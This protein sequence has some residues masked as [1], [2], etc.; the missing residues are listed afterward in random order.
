MEALIVGLIL[1]M[2]T[3]GVDQAIKLK[4]NK[5]STNLQNVAKQIYTK[6]SKNNSLLEK[7]ADAYNRNDNEL[8]SELLS[9][10]G[11]GTRATKLKKA[12]EEAQSS[13]N[14]EKQS[15][16]DQNTQLQ[17]AYNQA[18]QASYNTSDLAGIN[19][20]KEVLNNLGVKTTSG[21]VDS[22]NQLV[23]GGLKLNEVH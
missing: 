14:K 5:V 7:L 16:S 13:Y 11:F 20:G 4:G 21:S 23:E 18:S 9:G 8:M 6:I 1:A 22:V 19:Q 2:A 10:A 15:I 12:R 17:N 3:Y